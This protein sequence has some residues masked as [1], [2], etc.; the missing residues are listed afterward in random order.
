M[1]TSLLRIGSL[2]V[3]LLIS[4]A[5]LDVPTEINYIG[6]QLI[7]AD[8]ARPNKQLQPFTSNADGSAKDNKASWWTSGFYPGSLWY[9]YAYTHKPIYKQLAEQWTKGLE[10]E[11]YNTGTHDLGFMLYCSYGNGYRLTHDP[12]Y[13]AVLLNG[14]KSLATRFDPKVGLIKSWNTFKTYSYPVIIDNMMNLEYLLWA[15]QESGNPAYRQVAM[16]HADNT[17]KYHFRPDG[18][19][20]HV[21]AYNPDGTVAGK[22]THQGAADESAWARGQA[23]GLYGYTVMYRYTNEKRYIQMAEKIAQFFLNHKNL[24]ADKIPYWDFDRPG[25]ERDTSAGAIAASALLELSQYSKANGNTYRQAATTMLESL[26]SPAYKAALGSNSQFVLMHSTGHKPGNSEINVP[27][28]YADY[29]YLEGL[30]RLE[31]LKQKKP[32]FAADHTAS[33]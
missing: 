1:L 6:E 29:Y 10:Q 9:L 19:S 26:A 30:I 15:S 22:L 33:R 24:P 27:L 25:E 12:A 16:T 3:A 7:L 17:I 20:Y 21:I 18:S 11:Q 2:C 13:K 23:W 31:Q 14:A 4:G 28:V 32:L 5:A 8:K